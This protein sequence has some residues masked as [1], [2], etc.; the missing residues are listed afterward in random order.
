MSVGEIK[1]DRAIYDVYV[2]DKFNQ[3]SI[4]GTKNFKQYWS[5]NTGKELKGTISVTDH[6]MNWHE[7]A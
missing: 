3:P 5:V 1:V 7:W 2:I 4:D 6:F